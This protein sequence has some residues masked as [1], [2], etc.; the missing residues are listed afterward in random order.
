M[1]RSL[2]R[3]PVATIAAD[4]VFELGANERRRCCD[5]TVIEQKYGFLGFLG[6]RSAASS[7]SPFSYHKGDYER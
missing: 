2:V 1:K 6:Y 5:G 3:G 4:R 7:P